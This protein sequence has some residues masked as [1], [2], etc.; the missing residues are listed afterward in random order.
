MRNLPAKLT[1]DY[2]RKVAGAT[3]MTAGRFIGQ[4]Y[5]GLK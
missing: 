4:L 3:P 2:N 5:D 1:A